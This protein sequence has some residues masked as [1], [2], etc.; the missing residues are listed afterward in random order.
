MRP[1]RKIAVLSLV[2]AS[3]ACPRFS[4]M[5]ES[6]TKVLGFA[7]N[8]GRGATALITQY[9][10]ESDDPE[11]FIA[12]DASSLRA[13]DEEVTLGVQWKSRSVPFV[14]R[15]N[16]VTHCV[17]AS[18]DPVLVIEA[19][20]YKDFNPLPVCQARLNFQGLRDAPDGYQTATYTEDFVPGTYPATPP[21]ELFG[22]P[23]LEKANERER[24]RVGGAMDFTTEFL[25]GVNQSENSNHAPDF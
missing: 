11:P 20:C 21:E 13:G 9:D 18:S 17:F 16:Q 19:N 12:I 22:E 23:D 7:S 1:I 10:R 2:L 3:T 4:G 8:C 24:Q 15:I 14:V 6:T 5:P 25:D